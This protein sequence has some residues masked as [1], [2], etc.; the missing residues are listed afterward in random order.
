MF[1]DESLGFMG[2][3]LVTTAKTIVTVQAVRVANGKMMSV[4]KGSP[5]PAPPAPRLALTLRDVATGGQ[6][7]MQSSLKK[8]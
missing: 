8:A 2:G 1:F 3:A 6:L 7:A 4:G 5:P